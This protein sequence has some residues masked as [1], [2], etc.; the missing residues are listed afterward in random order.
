MADAQG[1]KFS[2]ERKCGT[3]GWGVP[4]KHKLFVRF[5]Q[6]LPQM[7]R[8]CPRPFQVVEAGPLKAAS[9]DWSVQ[10]TH[11]GPWV[12]RAWTER[13]CAD[14]VS[15]TSMTLACGCVR[16]FLFE[17]PVERWTEGIPPIRSTVL[18]VSP[19]PA[20]WWPRPPSTAADP[21][22]EHRLRASRQRASRGTGWGASCFGDSRGR[23]KRRS[24]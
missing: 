11:D 6:Y 8:H 17:L 18:H 22:T 10:G 3:R 20:I 5:G 4:A 14:V 13:T 1:I 21:P 16:S 24:C 2:L 23:L 9:C 7:G 19:E 15:T 12:P